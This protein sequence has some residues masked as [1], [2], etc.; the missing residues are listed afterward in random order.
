MS[1]K[2]R[3]CASSSQVTVQKSVNQQGSLHFCPFMIEMTP[4]IFEKKTP[5]KLLEFF[6]SFWVW[7][8]YTRLEDGYEF[9]WRFWI[10]Q[11]WTPA[12]WNRT[13]ASWNRA[14]LV[15]GRF[16][17]TETRI[18]L[19]AESRMKHFW[20]FLITAISWKYV[21]RRPIRFVTTPRVGAFHSPAIFAVLH[22]S[23]VFKHRTRLCCCLILVT[24]SVGRKSKDRSFWWRSLHEVNMSRRCV[25]DD[26][27]RRTQTTRA[28][29]S[30]WMVPLLAYV[31]PGLYW[32][33]SRMSIR[34]DMG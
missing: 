3:S 9:R 2:E 15:R 25:L 27:W 12:S 22:W 5:W 19:Q 32:H 29:V 4:W 21:G 33:Y 1:A 16:D 18:H 6:S 10:K 26:Q 17:S 8:L 30:R 7:T 28:R 23:F 31:Y 11:C 24:I 20:Q 34:V 14:T 13:P